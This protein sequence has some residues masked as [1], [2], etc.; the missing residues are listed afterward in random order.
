ME[1]DSQ[2]DRLPA[3]VTSFSLQFVL[4]RLGSKTVFPGLAGDMPLPQQP[5]ESMISEAKWLLFPA[6]IKILRFLAL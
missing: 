6:C 5:S 3:L 2:E 1:D 4:L